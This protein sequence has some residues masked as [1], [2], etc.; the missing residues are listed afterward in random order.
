MPAALSARGLALTA[1]AMCW[2]IIPSHGLRPAQWA[3]RVV[4]L[5]HA[6]KACRV[7]AEVNQGGAMVEQVLREVDGGL[8]FR[9]RAC[10]A[11]KAGKGRAGGGFV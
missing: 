4:A 8:S 11:G 6:R 3:K 7:V 10:H 2:M 9:S 5:Y 1:G